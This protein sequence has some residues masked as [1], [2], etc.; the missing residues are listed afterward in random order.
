MLIAE[1]GNDSPRI[2]VDVF[3]WRAIML[4]LT[5]SLKTVV[6]VT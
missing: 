3:V 6:T 1:F 5:R 2:G 4:I